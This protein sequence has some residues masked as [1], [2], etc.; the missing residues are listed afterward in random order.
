MGRNEYPISV[1]ALQRHKEVN[2]ITEIGR[3]LIL[4]SWRAG[5]SSLL[6]IFL[7]KKD[8]RENNEENIFL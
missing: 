2:G 6:K 4:L 7:F 8:C 3:K 1:A 5:Q